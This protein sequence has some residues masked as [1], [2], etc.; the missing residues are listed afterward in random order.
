MNET[1]DVIIQLYLLF[2]TILCV[3]IRVDLAAL[4]WSE[5]RCEI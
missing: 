4:I 3:L 2:Y 5:M 1:H